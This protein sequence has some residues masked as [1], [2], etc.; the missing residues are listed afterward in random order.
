MQKLNATIVSA[1]A[2]PAR[3]PRF[4]PPQ[5]NLVAAMRLAVEILREPAFLASDFDQIRTQRIAQIDRG[6]NR[7]WNA[8]ATDASKQPEA[9]SSNRRAA[10]SH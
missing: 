9:R 10:C 1:A 2:F 6:R 3:R 4:P 5:E 8:G 7:A